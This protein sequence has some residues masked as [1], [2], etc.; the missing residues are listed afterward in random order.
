MDKIAHGSALETLPAVFERIGLS[1][2][3]LEA[4]RARMKGKTLTVL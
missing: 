1:Q 2:L 4:G 3:C